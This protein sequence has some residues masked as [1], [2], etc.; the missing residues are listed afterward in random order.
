LA[1]IVAGLSEGNV[2]LSTAIISDVTTTEKR[3]K[4]LVRAKDII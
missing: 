3:S 2:Q 1:R 4:S